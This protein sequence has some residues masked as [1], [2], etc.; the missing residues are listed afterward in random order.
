MTI[1]PYVAQAPSPFFKIPAFQTINRK[2]LMEISRR[3]LKFAT[4]MLTGLPNRTYTHEDVAMLVWKHFP[5]QNL[6]TL[7]NN[8]VVL[9][10]QRR[11][12]VLFSSICAC[13]RFLQDQNR[14]PVFLKEVIP[15][16][17]LVLEDINLGS[18]EESM[19][20]SL[21]KWSN[22]HVP[23]LKSLEERL[24]IVGVS[25]TNDQIVMVVMTEVASIATFASFLPLANRIYIEM[26]ESTGVIKV[27]EKLSV[28]KLSEQHEAWKQVG[29][30][31]SLL[32][33]KERLKDC[34]KIG[35]NLERGTM[36]LN[37]AATP[38]NR[39]EEK[40]AA[41]S[42]VPAK[43]LTTSHKSTKCL[44]IDLNTLDEHV[45]LQHKLEQSSTLT[46]EISSESDS[47]FKSSSSSKQATKEMKISLSS[48]ATSDI[49]KSI[50][51]CKSSASSSGSTKSSLLSSST[52]SLVKT[53]KDA[54]ESTKSQTN[55]SSSAGGS[56]T[57]PFS[58]SKSVRSSA[59]SGEDKSETPLRASQTPSTSTGQSTGSP[60]TTAETPQSD[61]H[62]ATL[63]GAA[64]AKFDHKVSAESCI[65]KTQSASRVETSNFVPT[66]GQNLKFANQIQIQDC[67][68][69]ETLK[70][71]IESKE[72]EG[73]RDNNVKNQMKDSSDPES[74]QIT[75]SV[76]GQKDTQNC[77][78]ETPGTEKTQVL[79]RVG[80]HVSDSVEDQKEAFI[81]MEREA[82]FCPKDN[83]TKEH[84]KHLIKDEGSKVKPD[85]R[86]KAS[87]SEEG[88]TLPIKQERSDEYSETKA[89]D[90]NEETGERTMEM[91]C[92]DPVLDE[93]STHMCGGKT[94]REANE[95]ESNQ[96]KVS[97][98]V[99]TISQSGKDAAVEEKE[100][101]TD[102][103]GASV[104]EEKPLVKDEGLAVK[105]DKKS[106][107]SESDN[108]ENSA[109]K[110]NLDKRLETQ[111]KDSNAETGER[112]EEMACEDS[113]ED[114]SCR[115]RSFR[116]STRLANQDQTNSKTII[117]TSS[118]SK[119][120]TIIEKVALNGRKDRTPRRRNTPARDSQQ[121]NKA[122]S[123]K[124]EAM[125]VK[126]LTPTTCEQQSQEISDD[127]DFRKTVEEEKEAT[128]PR[129]RGRPK[130]TAGLALV[131]KSTNGMKF[132]SIGEKMM[133]RCAK[134]ETR[135]E[136][137]RDN[138]KGRRTP[139][140]S[141]AVKTL[142]QTNQS[143]EKE[144]KPTEAAGVK[145]EGKVTAERKAAKTAESKT[146]AAT[147]G[148]QPARRHDLTSKAD[149]CSAVQEQEHLVKDEGL[150]VK[151]IQRTRVSQSEDGESSSKKQKSSDKQPE[152]QSKDSSAEMETERTEEMVCK[153]SVQAKSGI[154]QTTRL[155]SQDKASEDK[156][157]TKAPTVTR[158][159]SRIRKI[160]ETDSSNERK[161][162]KT[163]TR[164]RTP[165]GDSQQQNEEKTLKTEETSSPKNVTP[166]TWKQKPSQEI[167]GDVNDF[168]KTREEEKEAATPR[169]RG[170]PKKI[171]GPAAER[172]KQKMEFS[173]PEPN[174]RRSRFAPVSADVRRSPY[175]P[176]RP[177]R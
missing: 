78:T 60:A 173:G 115:K 106:R 172:N 116:Q 48:P 150:A 8:V 76:A 25:G 12:F 52:S 4:I 13:L 87:T 73:K 81:K 35:V 171:V 137:S 110:Q 164:K 166:M 19:Y 68:K 100:I 2:T 34:R 6:H 144:A 160:T 154:R 114:K 22:I 10:L 84:S 7:Y 98:V 89:K 82:F 67:F 51:D 134:E 69:D 121:Q 119:R 148:D 63:T 24:L 143:Q 74:Y 149:S 70:E 157:A 75:D 96:Y 62:G 136:T 112:T 36:S 20:R 71:E 86:T 37:T 94:N 142:V 147:V 93:S 17:H 105:P 55:L 162:D 109:K 9:P 95:D 33:R 127:V 132:G 1:S 53:Q 50:K 123:Q 79:C 65:A 165:A 32:S 161:E 90:S 140:S 145:S 138:V 40:S 66:Q 91:V 21:M 167:S 57:F 135:E 28:R 122:K 176:R 23:E 101:A 18:T 177:P 26:A 97:S 113:V 44:Q 29:R 108:G 47:N 56:K 99:P 159:T 77:S 141:A 118:T 107:V 156:A 46:K 175:R 128:T 117:T 15:K 124:R 58:S 80:L 146:E 92:K 111:T 174:R 31:E 11:V 129:R 16:I 30:V 155:A 42:A 72:K 27:M 126:D 39:M 169:R 83:A 153:E 131:R 151:P 49:L 104:K 158:S 168:R 130:K 139:S 102:D 5:D 59:S 61:K 125:F 38:L 54:S 64:V 41:C 133:E 170:Q 43:S 152:R 45:V 88:A 14:K 163:P 120:R 85:Q 103:H 3:D